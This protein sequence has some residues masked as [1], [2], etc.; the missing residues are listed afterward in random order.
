MLEYSKSLKDFK[1]WPY[2]P[3]IYKMS[4]DLQIL[5][6]TNTP[7]QDPG[8]CAEQVPEAL[9]IIMSAQILCFIP[10]PKSYTH[11]FNSIEQQ[12]HGVKNI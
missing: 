5:F 12:K 4:F 1:I 9:Q 2:C 8:A 10:H 11:I 6:Y 3:L 7:E